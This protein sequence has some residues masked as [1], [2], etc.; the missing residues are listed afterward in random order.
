M[1]ELNQKSPSRQQQS[2]WVISTLKSFDL[3]AF[4]TPSSAF[5]TSNRLSFEVQTAQLFLRQQFLSSSTSIFFSHQHTRLH[6]CHKSK[7]ISDALMIVINLHQTNKELGLICRHLSLNCSVAERYTGQFCS[8]SD[9]NRQLP[10]TLGGEANR[11]GR[12]W[13]RSL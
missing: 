12:M 3:T 1:C 8:D 2:L 10:I 4:S 9:A 11:D 6:I 13:A 7:M 5:S